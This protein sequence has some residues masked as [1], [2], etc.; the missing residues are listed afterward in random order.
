MKT[1]INL[2]ERQL[3]SKIDIKILELQINTKL[4]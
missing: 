2:K 1:T 4:K 3:I